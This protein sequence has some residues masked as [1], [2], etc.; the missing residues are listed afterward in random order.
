MPKLW[1]ARLGEVSDEADGPDL[2][3]AHEELEKAIGGIFGIPD[4]VEISQAIFENPDVGT[5]V[6][7]DGQPWML[8]YKTEH[9]VSSGGLGC[10]IEFYDEEQR[11]RLVLVDSKLQIFKQLSNGS[12]AEVINLELIDEPEISEYA[13]VMESIKNYD[14]AGKVIAVSADDTKFTLVDD[15]VPTSGAQTFLEL[16][17]VENIKWEPAYGGG[18]TYRQ[19]LIGH[20]AMVGATEKLWPG[21]VVDPNFMF[22]AEADPVE[23]GGGWKYITGWKIG[24]GSNADATV[25][26]LSD[27]HPGVY[28]PLTP[29]I[30]KINLQYSVP[31]SGGL[32]GKTEFRIG[33][34]GC[35]K[36]PPATSHSKAKHFYFDRPDPPDDPPLQ[37]TMTRWTE[38]EEE[39]PGT[40]EGQTFIVVP[41][42]DASFLV[43]FRQETGFPFMCRPVISVSRIA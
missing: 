9:P 18:T 2:A 19:E 40:D 29:G 21:I 42:N 24:E 16:A 41:G 26:D 35:H 38:L 8:R 23:V 15:S 37:R 17:D 5:A 12:W 28:F 20:A 27:D 25:G 30:Y 36:W 3:L 6:S 13:D 4:K 22:W 32:T 10:G 7:G 39:G 34:G 31:S 11:K 14:G 33:C 1:K 43:R